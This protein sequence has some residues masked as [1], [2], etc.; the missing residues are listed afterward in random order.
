[1]HAV[2]FLI[3]VGTLLTSSIMVGCHGFSGEIDATAVAV[4]V[5]DGDTFRLDKAVNGSDRV[6]LADIDASEYGRPL[7]VEAKNFLIGLVLNKTVYLDIDDVYVYDYSGTGT[8]LVCVAYVNH[9]STHYKNVNKA[10]LDASL[11]KISEYPNEFKANTWNLYVPK[12]NMIPEFP[13]VKT[14]LFAT[15]AMMLIAIL[16]KRRLG[17]PSTS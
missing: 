16:P 17:K 15:I 6:R 1:M 4:Y 8:R 9:N 12:T 13:A 14:L 10:L 3:I 11:A 5:Y 2:V 7:Y